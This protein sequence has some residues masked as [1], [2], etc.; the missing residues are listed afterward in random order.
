MITSDTIQPAHQDVLATCC[1]WLEDGYQVRL[2][3]VVRTFGS[4]PRPVGSLAAIRG[5]GQLTGSVSGGCVEKQVAT[6]IFENGDTAVKKFTIG[7]STAQSFGL[8]CGGSLELVFETLRPA[9]WCFEALSMLE[10][11]TQVRRTLDLTSG[12][13][14]GVAPATTM[15]FEFDGTQLSHVFGSTWRLLLIGG[16]QL[17]QYVASF[18]QACDFQVLV[19]EPR[20]HIRLAWPVT[21]VTCI[22]SLPDEF[23]EQANLNAQTSLLALTHEP[24][25]DDMAL[26][27]VDTQPA[28][29]VGALGSRK[30]HQARLDRLRR[31]GA[32]DAGME[33][34]QGP[35]G[36]DIGSK[37]SAEIALSIVAALVKERSRS[38]GG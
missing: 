5:D 36:L 16:G 9:G 3:T 11:S 21:A 32:S 27:Q 6:A 10:K 30:S 4:S 22:D 37:S 8:S 29:F 24:S 38:T 34:I 28:L 35:V 2:A 25:L 17:S 18:A 20:E 15:E 33:R 26:L 19:C 1:A 13:P 7:D 23:V 14:S 31:L 12:K